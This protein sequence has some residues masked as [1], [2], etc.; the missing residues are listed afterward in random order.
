MARYQIV[1]HHIHSSSRAQHV[2]LMRKKRIKWRLDVG[3]R[4]ILENWVIRS[5]TNIKTHHHK[6]KK[7]IRMI[8]GIIKHN[9]IR[10]EIGLP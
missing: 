5:F 10:Y 2:H 1:I 8:E 6:K 7:A 4:K 3:A 9:G